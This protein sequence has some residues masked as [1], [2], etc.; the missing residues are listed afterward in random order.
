MRREERDRETVQIGLP[1]P[2][3]ARVS[4]ENDPLEHSVS[5]MFLK[6]CEFQEGN[7]CE[8]IDVLVFLQQLHSVKKDSFVGVLNHAVLNFFPIKKP[9]QVFFLRIAVT[10]RKDVPCFS[11]FMWAYFSNLR[12]V[13]SSVDEGAAKKYEA[14]VIYYV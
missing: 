8:G 14:L 3:V 5:P 1:K 12:S 7:I 11:I 9:V 6:K 13:F 4:K 10:R 2:T